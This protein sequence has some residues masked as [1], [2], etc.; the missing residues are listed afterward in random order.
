MSSSRTCA[1][2][3]SSESTCSPSVP[4][5]CGSSFS[6]SSKRLDRAQAHPRRVPLRRREPPH[7]LLIPRALLNQQRHRILI[8]RKEFDQWSDAQ[9]QRQA[10]PTH[11]HAAPASARS[12]RCRNQGPRPRPRCTLKQPLTAVYPSGRIAAKYHRKDKTASSSG[13]FENRDPHRSPDQQQHHPHHHPR[14]H[15]QAAGQHNP[16]Q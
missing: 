3:I 10:A 12:R 6:A 1:Y 11:P 8:R 7:Q 4:S 13:A 2:S 5:C 16:Q 14:R 9:P 15:T